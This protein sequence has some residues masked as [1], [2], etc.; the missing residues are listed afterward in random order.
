M[1]TALFLFI[2]FVSTRHVFDFNI[3]NSQSYFGDIISASLINIVAYISDIIK[4]LFPWPFVFLVAFISIV[5]SQSAVTFMF[6]ILRFV[7]KIKI[8][9]T[10]FELGDVVKRQIEGAAKELAD[11]INSYS[12][13]A[14]I[15]IKSAAY[16]RRIYETMSYFVDNHIAP[17]L[18]NGVETGNFRCTIYVQDYITST[19]LYQLVEYFPRKNKK[20]TAG[21]VFSDRY[22]IIGKIW[23]SETSQVVG[24]LFHQNPSHNSKSQD[25]KIHIIMKDWG[26]HKDEA[27]NAIKKPS[28][29]CAPIFTPDSGKK[30]GLIFMDSEEKDTFLNG[31]IMESNKEEITQELQ[32]HIN[33]T[34]G[35]KLAEMEDEFSS[36]RILVDLKRGL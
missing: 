35:R 23:R 22:G 11:T 20:K 33:D 32:N 36:L 12:R 19:N 10:E 31:N 13:D 28:Y 24:N 1:F 9:G 26:M 7:R 29:L 8:L 4:S 25:E 27:E 18:Q 14:D 2:L 34:F 17:Y 30:I 15:K 5:Y 16:E 6:G 21:R 3:V